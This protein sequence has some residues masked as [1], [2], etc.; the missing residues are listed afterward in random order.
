MP[1]DL[2][3]RFDTL[4][5]RRGSHCAKWD[6]MEPIYGR[7]RRGRPGDVGGRHGLPPAPGR[8]RRRVQRMLDHGVVGYF[9]NEGPYRDAI[10][11]WMCE[12]HGWD[13]DADAIFTTHG[14]VNGTSLCVDTWTD[15]G[16]GVVLF[17]PV[18]HAFAKVI[19]ANGRRVVECEA[20][21]RRRALHPRLRRLG[22]ADR[23]RGRDDGDPLL[24]AQPRTAGSGR[25]SNWR[26]SRRW[27]SAT[28]CSW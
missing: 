26:A 4:I 22:R 14:L 16:D 27:R 25:G 15:P 18:Y 10:R 8:A 19:R 3:P 5:D 28:V 23:A 21:L 2:D 1:K 12:R 13:V 20:G 11:W 17:T 9:G 6:M 7:A 24:A